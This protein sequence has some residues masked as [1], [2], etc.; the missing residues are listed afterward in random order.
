MALTNEQIV[1]VLK[2]RELG[3]IPVDDT[4]YTDE[5][6]WALIL[7]NSGSVNLAASTIWRRKAAAYAE[8]VDVSEGSSTRK[9]SQLHRQAIDMATSLGG[10]IDTMGP[11]SSRHATVR[12]IE[13][14]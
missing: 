14:V 4:R 10:E 7:E 13:R 3:A 1:E 5:V 9:L 6:L 12:P 2:L 11:A 8:L